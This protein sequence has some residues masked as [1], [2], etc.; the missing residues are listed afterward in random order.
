[1]K[2]ICIKC[3][4]ESENNLYKFKHPICSICHRFSPNQEEK[5]NEYIRERISFLELESFRK[6]SEIGRPQKR[7]MIKKASEGIPMSR[8]PFGYKYKRGDL[9][10]SENWREVGEIFEEFLNLNLSLRKFSQKR[11]FSINGIKKI[12]GN[13]TYIGKIKFNNQIFEGNHK[14]IISSTLF[15]RVQNK[16]ENKKR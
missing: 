6:F 12:L 2:T 9:I 13:F 10:P 16:L 1:M 3:R 14:P 4:Y 7:G 11:G 15:N 5:F 8:P